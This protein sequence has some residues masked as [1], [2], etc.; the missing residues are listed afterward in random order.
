METLVCQCF[1]A[2]DTPPKTVF[3]SKVKAHFVAPLLQYSVPVGGL[4]VDCF[5][6]SGSTLLA[7]RLV[8]R[9]AVGIEIDERYCAVAV[10]RLRQ[11]VL[12]L[13]PCLTVDD[14]R[15]AV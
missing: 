12:E 2:K 13:E 4:V 7:A 8:G 14:E 9:Q 5:A 15:A 1:L 11:G 6:G 10:E 3:T